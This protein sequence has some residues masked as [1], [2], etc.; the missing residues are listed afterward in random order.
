MKKINL[1]S[2]A[3]CHERKQAMVT[4]FSN[5]G[6]DYTTIEAVDGQDQE[7]IMDYEMDLEAYK[8]LY[9]KDARPGEVGCYMSH[10]S[11]MNYIASTESDYGIVME[12]DV[13]LVAGFEKKDIEDIIVNQIGKLPPDWGLIYPGNPLMWGSH[14][15][16]D[17]DYKDHNP[18]KINE[19]HFNSDIS[20]LKKALIGTQCYIISLRLAEHIL[21]HWNTFY[22]PIDEVFRHLCQ[23]G[24]WS[25]FHGARS[26]WWC[27][28][29]F[30]VP[31]EITR[32]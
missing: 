24:K 2:L 11:A 1:I 10:L 26:D 6:L 19:A 15:Y 30:N 16:A 4:A 14:L 23:E 31:S 3:R 13:V 12:D 21:N 5:L 29:N 18:H 17:L 25:F 27:A 8:Y 32:T 9:K 28:P 7:A 22:R 20:Q